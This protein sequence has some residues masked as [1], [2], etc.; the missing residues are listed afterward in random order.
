MSYKIAILIGA[1]PMS[2]RSDELEGYVQAQ[3]IQASLKR[4]GFDS[5]IIRVGL[6]M[7]E[8][9]K[10]SDLKPF[11]VFNLVEEINNNCRLAF[12]APAIL[13]SL[14][15]IFSG[16]SSLSYALCTDKI[17]TKKILEQ[18]GLP[19]ATWSLDGLDLSGET[20][21]IIKSVYEDASF[22]IDDQSIV[23]ANLAAHA[24]KQKK[25]SD[26]GS[27]FAE[28]YLD[29]REFNVSL[30][31]YNNKLHVFPVQEL[32]FNNYPDSRPRI[33]GYD[34]KWQTES[35]AYNNTSRTFLNSHDPLAQE[36]CRLSK[37]AWD[38]LGLSGYARIDFRLDHKNQINILEVNPNP[39]LAPDAGFVAA[40]EQVG[41]NYDQLIYAMLPKSKNYI[42][43]NLILRSQ[44]YPTDIK[45]LQKIITDSGFFTDEEVDIAVELL[46]LG[47]KKGDDSGYLFY[48]AEQNSQVLGYACYGRIMSTLDRYDLYWIAVD[49]TL[50]RQ[51]V[52][53]KLLQKV[54]DAIIAR[55]GK[56]IYVQTAGRELY[57]PTRA[58]YK[59]AGYMQASVLPD[60]YSSGDDQIIF[61]KE[62]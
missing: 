42:Q 17:A 28:N 52:G 3:A 31:Y 36:L 7:L 20:Q 9:K 50:S 11:F 39:S 30:L 8:Y 46:E 10:I 44:I 47:Y 51:G 41:M 24:L 22:G 59:S 21:V 14:G 48:I 43:D 16:A 35:F 49:Q 54:E 13:E 4:L 25:L 40:A 19:T 1:D 27:W 23:P 37:L 61:M 5:E 2:T 26:T 15:I 34:A 6:D 33:V 62:L 32:V 12:C 57:E 56:R 18:A 38:L 53:R 55:A 45:A 29:G 60:Y 58:F